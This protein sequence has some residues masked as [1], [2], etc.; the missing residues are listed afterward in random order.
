MNAT[1]KL[2]GFT[3]LA[4]AI[5]ALLAITALDRGS[6]S[7]SSQQPTSSLEA[8]QSLGEPAK[9]SSSS[10]DW[11]DDVKKLLCAM[12]CIWDG[13]TAEPNSEMSKK[14]CHPCPPEPPGPAFASG[15]VNAML[16]TVLD[17]FNENGVPQGLSEEQKAMALAALDELEEMLAGETPEELDEDVA[18]AFLKEIPAMRAALQ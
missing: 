1:V 8:K 6:V 5:F 11:T 16:T 12:W 17:Y 15:D 14:C 13:C 7:A 4:S 18:A 9:R 3:I 2:G 10:D